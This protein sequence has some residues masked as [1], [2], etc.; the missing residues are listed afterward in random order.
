MYYIVG[1]ILSNNCFFVV[2]FNFFLQLEKN[3]KI[4]FA[5]TQLQIFVLNFSKK[6]VI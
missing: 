1:L 2:E 4:C 5:I 3:L 6:S